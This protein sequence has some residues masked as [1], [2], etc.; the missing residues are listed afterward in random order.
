MVAASPPDRHLL[1]AVGVLRGL[2]ELGYDGIA[3]AIGHA[4]QHTGLVSHELA[5]RLG[6]PPDAL[7]LWAQGSFIPRTHHL[8]CLGKV[9]AD[10]QPDQQPA[11]VDQ[12][13]RHPP[14]SPSDPPT[15]SSTTR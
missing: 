2:A 6:L 10:R 15:R 7:Q 8:L 9:L 12:P 14:Q 13:P 5:M 11:S 1:D 3:Q 4:Q